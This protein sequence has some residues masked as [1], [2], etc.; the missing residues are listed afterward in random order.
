M[1]SPS[2]SQV[3]KLIY[4]PRTTCMT[5]EY[6]HANTAARAASPRRRA[7]R[8]ARLAC[9]WGKRPHARR[10]SLPKSNR[11]KTQ[12]VPSPRTCQKRKANDTP[13]NYCNCDRSRHT[14]AA[15]LSTRTVR[16]TCGAGG[17][18]P[19]ETGPPPRSSSTAPERDQNVGGT[20]TKKCGTDQSWAINQP[21]RQKK[22]LQ[23]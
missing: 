20:L 23:L 2:T 21:L 10:R 12:K 5:E 14:G 1:A 18:Q 9:A 19:G 4:P 17:R 8:A 16:L 11:E 22:A 13:T 7:G 6:T 15:Q 3:L